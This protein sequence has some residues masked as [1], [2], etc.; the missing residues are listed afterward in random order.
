MSA[1]GTADSAAAAAAQSVPLDAAHLKVLPLQIP[2]NTCAEVIAALDT[3]GAGVD[4][5]L[6]DTSTGESSLARARHVVSDRRCA[7][8]SAAPASIEL[9]LATGKGDALVLIRPGVSP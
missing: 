4:L 7:G 6:V 5:R 9:R 8:A 1:A 3:E 2:A